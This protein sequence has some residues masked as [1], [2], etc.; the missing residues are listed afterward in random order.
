VGLHSGGT[1]RRIFV[2][3]PKEVEYVILNILLPLNRDNVV[4]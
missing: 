1:G 4:S 2:K 3:C